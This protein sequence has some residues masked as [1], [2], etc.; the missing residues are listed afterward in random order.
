MYIKMHGSGNVKFESS[1]Y[2]HAVFIT[3]NYNTALPLGSG[4]PFKFSAQS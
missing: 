3:A 4:S 1:P 2:Y